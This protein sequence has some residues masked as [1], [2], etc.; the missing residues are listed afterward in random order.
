VS[1]GGAEEDETKLEALSRERLEEVGIDIN[2]AEIPELNEFALSGRV[3]CRVCFTLPILTNALW[4]FLT[5][6]RG[7]A[8]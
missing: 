2:D 3:G 1:F 5:I 8:G 6:G 4:R 7:G